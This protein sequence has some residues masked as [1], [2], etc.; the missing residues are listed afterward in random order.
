MPEPLAH[1][2]NLLGLPHP[3]RDHLLAVAALAAEFAAGFDSAEYARCAGLLHD[4][5]K[6]AEAFQECLRRTEDAHIEVSRTGYGDHA[7]AGAI[8][9]LEVFGDRLGLP[10]AFVVAGHHG[11]LDDRPCLKARLDDPG[12]KQRLAV[13][14]KN[15]DAYF[16]ELATPSLTAFLLSVKGREFY[17]RYELWVRMLFSCLVD[18]DFLDTEA[19]FDRH[20]A[21]SRG[22]YPSL[23]DLKGCYDAHMAG[24]AATAG[25]VNDVRRRVLADCR[26]AGANSPQGVFTLTAPTGCGKTLAAM[27]FA[28]EHAVARGLDRVIVVIPFTSII[29]Q[30]AAVYREVFGPENVI[31]HHASLDPKKETAR[32]RVACENWDAPVVV[33]T[34]VQFVESLFANKPSRCRKLHNIVNSVVVFDEVQTLPIGHLAPILGVLKELVDN[35]KVSLVLSTATQPAL[36]RRPSLPDGFANAIEIVSH[37][38]E[39]FA[40][41]RR[42][43]V[44]WPPTLATPTTWPDLAAEL[45]RHDEVLCVVHR[46]EDARQLA[47]LVPESIHLSALMCPAHR[48]V[49]IKEVKKRLEANRRRR[50]RSEPIEPVR[51]ISTQ[52][53]EAGVDVD[54]PEVYRAAGGLDSIAQAAGRC[55]REGRL[56]GRLGQV[57]VFV[58]PTPPPRG[59]SQTGLEVTA[60]MREAKPDLDPLDPGVF[61]EFF[62]RLYGPNQRDKDGI[63]ALRQE[64]M[65]KAVGDKFTL[66]EDDGNEPVVVPYCNP[67]VS[68]DA[69]ARL[70]ELRRYGPGRDRSRALQ[71]FIVNLFPRQIQIL[72]AAGAIEEVGDSV[73]AIKIPSFRHLYNLR[74]GLALT[75]PVLPDPSTL[76]F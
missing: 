13:A 21:V 74:F 15:P 8:H 54:F 11:G 31:D 24:L 27:G 28:L 56:Q 49:V 5:G 2:P 40:S 69:E 65:F 12:K 10:L 76:T 16:P 34:S 32:N 14:R 45:L 60:I 72:E 57:R 18:A 20:K 67:E 71:P 23:A 70:E 9:A 48:L 68:A 55:N 39:V 36:K 59:V 61:E 73:R 42:V 51:L 46:R 43:N 19:H 4:L 33:T 63:Q 17:H 53:I 62:R 75:E 29:D 52:L 66:I 1:S 30:N 22:H 38:E 47:E 58:A 50:E 44:S 41:L 26:Q 64:L 3:L 6:N 37:V 25:T 35:Y 7:S